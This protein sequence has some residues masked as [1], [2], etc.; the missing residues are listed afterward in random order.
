MKLPVL[1]LICLI[2]NPFVSAQQL[3]FPNVAISDDVRVS[4]S[5]SALAEQVISVYKDSD[6]DRYLN[7]LFQLQMVAGKYAEADATINSLRELRRTSNAP[8]IVADRDLGKVELL[9]RH[10]GVCD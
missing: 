3:D 2:A 1:A 7:N 5:M 10:K 8:Y 6:R 9:R 4:E